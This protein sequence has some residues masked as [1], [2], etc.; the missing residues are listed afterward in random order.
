MFETTNQFMSSY[1]I[2]T[3]RCEQFPHVRT[4]NLRGIHIENIDTHVS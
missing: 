3:A 4:K 1:V 2:Q